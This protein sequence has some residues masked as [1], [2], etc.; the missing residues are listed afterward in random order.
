M[1]TVAKSKTSRVL[2]Y[3]PP[4]SGKTELVGRL[5]EKYNLIWFDAEQG[6]ETLTKLPHEQ[7]KRIQL[8]S[9][10]DSK[11]YPI[12]AETWLKVIKGNKQKI[13]TDHGKVTCPLCARNSLAVYDEVELSS[14]PENTIV[15]FDSLTQLSNSFISH[16]TKAQP[17]D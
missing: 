3:G 10:Q 2:V 13:C 9:I 12:A 6:W 5:A 11:T 4:K 1:D 8:I 14:T 17:D 7:Q 16:I 15:V